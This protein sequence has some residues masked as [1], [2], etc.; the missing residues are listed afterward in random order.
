MSALVDSP[1]MPVSYH[2][3]DKDIALMREKYSGLAI[4]DSKSYEVVR[5]AIADCRTTRVAL[6]KRRLELNAEAQKHIKDVN[7]AAKTMIAAISSIED[8]LQALKDAEDAR[9]AK[10]KADREAAER[11]VL[12]EAARKKVEEEQAQWAE[13]RK[14]EEE[15]LKKEAEAQRLEREKLEAERRAF[16][17]QQAKLQREAEA[18]RIADE[19]AARA[20]AMKPDL[21]KLRA[22]GKKIRSISPPAVKSDAA[23]AIVVKVFDALVTIADRLEAVS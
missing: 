2:V 20:E 22:F 12:E 21:E 18:K 19:A 7:G 16:E 3:G 11:A 9:K 14:D 23:K 6:D 10:E 4:N 8:P 13:F 17:E 5:L 1:S 15:R